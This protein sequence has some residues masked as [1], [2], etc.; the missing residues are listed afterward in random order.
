MI[1]IIIVCAFR[2]RRKL[3]DK[4]VFQNLVGANVERQRRLRKVGHLALQTS[5]L[6]VIPLIWFLLWRYTYMTNDYCTRGKFV[7]QIP[8]LDG[9]YLLVEI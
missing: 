8:C 1:G 5:F 2:V 6:N 9:G 4:S 3:K 7:T